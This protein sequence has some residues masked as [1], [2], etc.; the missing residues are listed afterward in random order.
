MYKL[1]V[2]IKKLHQDAVIP[3][4][5]TNGSAG[6]DFH[7]LED[8]NIYPGAST[9]VKTGIS[10]EIPS[11]YEIQVR[12][13]SGLSAKTGIRIANSPGTIDEDFRGEI[14]IIV[15]NTHII[16]NP[17]VG[18]QI[19]FKPFQIKKGDRIAQGVLCPVFQAEFVEEELGD[20]E[21][22]QGG[23]GHSGV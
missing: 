18:Q 9:V 13:R 21:R 2:K 19:E 16:T 5:A 8:V 15:E 7:A 1:K 4:Y 12:P 22:G 10:M 6:F 14:G 11:G 3:K 17:V 20:T 23:F